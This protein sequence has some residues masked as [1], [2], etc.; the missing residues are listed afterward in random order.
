MPFLQKKSDANRCLLPVGPFGSAV[1]VYTTYLLYL[2]VLFLRHRNP[3]SFHPYR[4][5]RLQVISKKALM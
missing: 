5:K 2:M 3:I 4:M 1:I